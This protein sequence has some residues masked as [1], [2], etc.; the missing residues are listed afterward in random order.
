MLIDV[1]YMN[2]AIAR[3]KL[4]LDAYSQHLGILDKVT[5]LHFLSQLWRLHCPGDALWWQRVVGWTGTH[6]PHPDSWTALL[7]ARACGGFCAAATA[8]VA[9]AAGARV[10]WSSS[11]GEVKYICTVANADTAPEYSVSSAIADD[12]DEFMG[13]SSGGMGNRL[14]GGEEG[15]H[16]WE[17]QLVSAGKG[18]LLEEAGALAEDDLLLDQLAIAETL[19]EGAVHSLLAIGRDSS[20]LLYGKLCSLVGPDARHLLQVMRESMDR[21]HARPKEDLKCLDSSCV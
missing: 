9:A 13:N 11:S 12:D 7:G 15:V 20:Q 21:V 5:V 3:S 8:T 10:A 4:K 19:L 16:G 1:C 14:E 17:D 6:T 18:G 2:I